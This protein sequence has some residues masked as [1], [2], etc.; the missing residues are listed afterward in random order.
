MKLKGVA[1]SE[2]FAYLA[3]QPPYS[4]WRLEVIDVS[5]PTRP[6]PLGSF[7]YGNSEDAQLN[8]LAAAGDNL[9]L[10]R[11]RFVELVDVRDPSTPWRLVQYMPS[12]KP[13]DET[14]WL[15]QVVSQV[16]ISGPTVL[17]SVKFSAEGGLRFDGLEAI[18]FTVPGDPQFLGR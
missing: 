5:N 18:D 9:Y 12:P 15:I 4:R 11:S 6:R 8:D 1:V 16:V 3:N 2:N 10:A 13:D 14:P 7:D 17:A